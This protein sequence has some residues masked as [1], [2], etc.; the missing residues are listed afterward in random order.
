M[1]QPCE[2]SIFLNAIEYEDSVGREAYLDQACRDDKQLRRSVDAL[3]RA[4]ERPSHPLDRP[5]VALPR[6]AIKSRV[7]TTIGPYRL[8]EQ[9]GEGGFGLVFVAQQLSPVRRQV[10]LKI[11]KPGTE[12]KE[13]IARFE[14]ERQALAMMNHPHIAQVLDAG[15]TDEGHPFFVMELVR[16]VPVTQ[17]ADAQKLA[18]PE[19]LALFMDV[20]NAVHHAHQKGVIHRDIKPSNVIVTLHDARA[21]A[22]VID[23]GVAKAIGPS[24]TNKTIYTRFFSMIGTPLYMSPEQ[25]EMNGLDIDTRSDI[26]SLGV[27]LYELLVGKPPFDRQRLESAGLDEL[28]HIIREEEPP[29]PSKRVTTLNAQMTTTAAVR[30]ID[31]RRFSSKLQGDLDWIVMKAM[32][33]DRNRR[34]DSAASMARDIA[35]HL[36]QQP[37]E[38][39]PPTLAYQLAKFARRQRTALMTTSLV[40]IAM[41]IGTAASIWQMNEAIKER[42]EKEI[43]LRDANAAKKQLELF[44]QGLTTAHALIAD[45]QTHAN[46][47]RWRLAEEHYERAI[48]QYP[49]YFLPWVSRAQFFANRTLWNEAADDYAK[50]ISLGVP[51]DSPQFYGVAGLL[52]WT[53]R[54][55]AASV[56][57]RQLDQRIQEELPSQAWDLVRN[58]VSA[59]QSIGDQ[60]FAA[61]A[62]QT[63]R[64]LREGRDHRQN[65]HPRPHPPRHAPPHPPGPHFDFLGPSPPPPRREPARPR[66]DGV[67]NLPPM[68]IRLYIAGLTQLRAGDIDAALRHFEQALADRENPR[69]DLLR[70]PLAIAYHQL[71]RSDAPAESGPNR[72]RPSSE[73]WE[74]FWRTKIPPAN[75]IGL[76]SL[77]CFAFTGK[78]RCL[79][80]A[81][82]WRSGRK[83]SKSSVN[84]LAEYPLP[85][86]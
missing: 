40:I 58:C 56:F 75:C 81:S 29:L 26:Y 65:E 42:N 60:R 16:G 35:R 31:P 25:A 73:H 33:K 74:T 55:H 72:R 10:A 79:S 23:F 41:L 47:K 85:I 43:A 69:K 4:H 28:R 13:V 62:M 77:K 54:D 46:A 5:P 8:M 63:E 36:N 51:I 37:I 27:L 44:A 82:P 84:V 9:I 49:N 68:P 6:P 3:L 38:A 67:G 1:S 19:R 11:I 20:C 78:R 53:Q 80:K 66:H 7:G 76:I 21:V 48:Q 50:A 70:A 12:S 17:F 18:L 34:Y 30:Q 39:R 32:E 15:V 71:D 59:P 45:A 86:Q 64:W 22:K 52:T 83:W 61:L 57:G 14:A 24:L 2:Q